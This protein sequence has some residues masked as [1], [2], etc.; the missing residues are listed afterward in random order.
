MLSLKINKEVDG[1]PLYAAM[2]RLAQETKTSNED[3][4]TEKIEEVIERYIIRQD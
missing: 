4:M 1:V 3:A 2:F